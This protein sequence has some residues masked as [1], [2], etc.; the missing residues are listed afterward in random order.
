[1]PS[2]SDLQTRVVSEVGDLLPEG[3]TIK[4]IQSGAGGR[5]LLET[6]GERRA[7]ELGHH[8]NPDAVILQVK[9]KLQRISTQT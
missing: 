2:S 9:R 6:P 3:S 5:V 1:M 7:K 4:V 8:V